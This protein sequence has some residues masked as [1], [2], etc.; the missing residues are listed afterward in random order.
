MA[1]GS[2]ATVK[3]ESLTGPEKNLAIFIDKWFTS[4]K[5]LGLNNNVKWALSGNLRDI[6]AGVSSVAIVNNTNS[7]VTSW[8]VEKGLNESTSL[9]KVL[10]AL[11]LEKVSR[12]SLDRSVP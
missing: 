10:T 5:S 4:S 3:G 12:A 8:V 1:P 2:T 9:G 6:G 7:D 11:V